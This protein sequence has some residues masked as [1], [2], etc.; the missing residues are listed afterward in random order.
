MP[1]HVGEHLPGPLP[2]HGIPRL[3]VHVEDR[4][5]RLRP[6]DVELAADVHLLVLEVDKLRGDPRGLR[7]VHPPAHLGDCRRDLHVL[8]LV[9]APVRTQDQHAA[10]ET[11]EVVH[12]MHRVISVVL[13]DVLGPFLFAVEHQLV[14]HRAHRLFP[15]VVP[16]LHRLGP[17]PLHPH[18]E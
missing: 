5:D 9:V 17:A 10:H 8:V 3:P 11:R 18:L 16:T 15:H 14:D 13:G 2:V 4:L 12:L 7:A 1:S 6:L